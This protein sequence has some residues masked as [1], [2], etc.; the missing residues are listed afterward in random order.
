MDLAKAGKMFKDIKEL[1]D[2]VFWDKGLKMRAIYTILKKVKSEENANDQRGKKTKKNARTGNP[3]A[4]VATS[5]EENHPAN[6]R[7]LAMV[8]EATYGTVS[9][10]IHHRLSLVK[11]SAC[12]VPKLQMAK[13]VGTSTAF[14]KLV[15]AESKAVLKNIISMDEMAIVMHIPETKTLSKL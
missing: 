4:A 3:N 2:T 14:V 5:I 10:I 7:G 8:H 15:Q 11:K 13:R 6:I 1:M 12:W 9:R